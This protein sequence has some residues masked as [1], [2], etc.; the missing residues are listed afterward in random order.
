MLNAPYQPSTQTPPA[1]RLKKKWGI[2]GWPFFYIFALLSFIFF[3]LE[4]AYQYYILNAG[5]G[6]G[7][8]IRASAL[9]GTTLTATAL[10]SSALFKWNPRWAQYWRIRRF[11]GVSGFVFILIHVTSVLWFIFSWNIPILFYSWNPVKNPLVFG[12][13]A[14]L[15]LFAM[16]ATSFDWA[17]KKLGGRRWKNIHRFV[18]IAF[19]A[20]IFHY[21][22]INPLLLY[23]PAGYLLM[24]MT[25][26][27][28]FG[29]LFWF[30]KIAGAKKFK[31]KGALVG[32][33]I[34][35]AVLATATAA[36]S[37]YNR[38]SLSF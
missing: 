1:A 13:T 25:A 16:A 22:L 21:T 8:L 2:N 37:Y 6:R 7:S 30:F 14:F 32:F 36:I 19:P 29:Q 28:L 23:N 9:T 20:A 35:A 4:Y 11:L 38:G 27:A 17:V 3:L 5:D 10:F 24:I 26:A 18:Y 31:T 15:I 33:T 34:I 12:L